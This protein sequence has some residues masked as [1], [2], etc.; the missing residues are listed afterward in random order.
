MNPTETGRLVNRGLTDLDHSRCGARSRDSDE[1][2][3]ARSNDAPNGGVCCVA[4]RDRVCRRRSGR[5]SSESPGRPAPA[6]GSCGAEP[7]AWETGRPR[8]PRPSRSA[9]GSRCEPPRPDPLGVDALPD[10]PYGALRRAI[11]LFRKGDMAEGDRAKAA[12]TDPVERSL[13]EWVAVRFGWVGFERIAAFGART[14]IGRLWRHWAVAPKR[15]C[16]WPA[17]PRRS[18][19]PFSPSSSPRPPR[20]RSPC[21]RPQERG[22]GA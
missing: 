3:T 14:L 18:C 7:A 6:R 22:G 11:E 4:R 1:T 13:S 2:E 21:A 5:A 15:P 19:A 10:A 20:A 16:S 17:N 8:S 9:S 12:L